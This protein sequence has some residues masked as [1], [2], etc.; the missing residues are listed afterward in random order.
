MWSLSQN[1]EIDIYLRSI[2]KYIQKL[3]LF[4]NFCKNSVGNFFFKGLYQFST[5]N[6]TYSYKSLPL[7]IFFNSYLVKAHCVRE[8]WIFR[9]ATDSLGALRQVSILPHLWAFRPIYHSLSTDNNLNGRC[10]IRDRR[11]S[12]YQ[13]SG[14]PIFWLTSNWKLSPEAEILTMRMGS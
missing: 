3:I 7:G 13:V 10:T 2:C 6:Y 5:I 8:V 14:T 11:L 1:F 4:N 9:L 12:C